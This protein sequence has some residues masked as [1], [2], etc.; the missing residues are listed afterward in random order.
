MRVQDLFAALAGPGFL[1][2]F[3][4]DGNVYTRPYT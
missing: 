2:L 3:L 1:S 4:L